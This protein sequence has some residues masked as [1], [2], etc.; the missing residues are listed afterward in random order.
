MADDRALD[1]TLRLIRDEVTNIVDDRGLVSAL[2]TTEVAL[3]GDRT[4]LLSHAAQSAYVTAALLLARS[5]HTVHLVAPDVPLDGMQ[6][7]LHADTLVAGLMEVGRDLLPGC[8]FSI[9]N[10]NHR[11]D[12][13]VLFS[14]LAWKGLADG[15]LY[16]SGS[17]WRGRISLTN[18]G[19]VWSKDDW[20]I[21]A[22]AC[23]DLIASEAFKI[24]V[25][26]LRAFASHPKIFDDLFAPAYESTFELAPEDTPTRFNLRTFDLVSC[27]AIAQASLF[28]LARV[29]NVCGKIRLFEPDVSDITNLNRNM[30][31]RRSSVGL[32]KAREI[33][34]QRLGSISMEVFESRYEEERA[35]QR[36]SAS[37]LVGVDHIPTRWAVQSVW[38]DWL[39]V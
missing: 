11:I 25:R 1:R 28:S 6:P 38:P 8:E 39:A 22:L 16:A 19:F 4:T 3:V 34:A 31:L 18:P 27:G 24:A 12:L 9:G 26:K 35:A 33:A 17:R 20:P 30:L 32:S 5:G 36:P 29:P 10:P 14:D 23:A 2:S 15:M 7:P 37:V 13:A 21:G